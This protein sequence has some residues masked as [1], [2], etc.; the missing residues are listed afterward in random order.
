M[1]P[2][3]MAFSKAVTLLGDS[4]AGQLA[5]MVNQIAIAGLVQGFVGGDC[6]RPEGRAST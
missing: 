3:A 1:Q 4:G 6:L 2:V 5:K